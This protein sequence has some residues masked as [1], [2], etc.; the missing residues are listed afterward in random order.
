LLDEK[1]RARG[2][3][4]GTGK[5]GTANLPSHAPAT[6]AAAARAGQPKPGK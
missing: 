6:V 4:P 1:D 2:L 5:G 3:V